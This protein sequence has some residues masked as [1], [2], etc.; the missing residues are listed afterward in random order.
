MENNSFGFNPKIWGEYGAKVL[1]QL[2]VLIVEVDKLKKE[3]DIAH[4]EMMEKISAIKND[5]T[6][7]KTK[8]SIYGAVAGFV[9][10]AIMSLLIIFLRK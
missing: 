9:I 3:N 7:I 10:S 5:I 4:K 2:E 6:I 8:A 1:N